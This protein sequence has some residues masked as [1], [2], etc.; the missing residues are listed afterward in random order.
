MRPGLIQMHTHDAV[1]LQGSCD[2]SVR[3]KSVESRGRLGLH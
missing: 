2:V 3:G 1:M